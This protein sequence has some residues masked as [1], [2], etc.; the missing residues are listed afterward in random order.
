MGAIAYPNLSFGMV[1]ALDF[2]G[3]YLHSTRWLRRLGAQTK[4]RLAATATST[5]RDKYTTLARGCRLMR[6]DRS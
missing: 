6:L 1:M 5:E 2:R 4:Q 3:P